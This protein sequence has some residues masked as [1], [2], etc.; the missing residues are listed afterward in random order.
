M[1]S[2]TFLNSLIVNGNFKNHINDM[3]VAGSFLAVEIEKIHE[4]RSEVA[5]V[6]ELTVP[7][8][9]HVVRYLENEGMERKVSV[10]RLFLKE[11]DG[12]AL[13]SEQ[14]KD[15]ESIVRDFSRLMNAINA[16][17]L[18]KKVHI[19]I[20]APA[21]LALGIGCIIRNLNKPYIY[22]FDRD[23]QS[24]D[25]VIVANDGLRS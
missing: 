9:N 19:F 12:G 14:R 1:H 18:P 25:L 6:L 4:L 23:K 13:D 3:N 5:I 17:L 20:A 11:R 2:N 10:L 16:E 22:H 15:W 21:S 24:Y 7:C 8:Y